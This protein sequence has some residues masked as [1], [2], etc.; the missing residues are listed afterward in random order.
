M[1][2]GRWSRIAERHGGG[3]S[4]CPGLGE[5]A[6]DEVEKR[7]SDWLKLDDSFT[8]IL[9]DCI[10]RRAALAPELQKNIDEAL[11]ELERIQSGI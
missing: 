2:L 6:I 11:T 9:R 7:V 5:V 8:K 10:E 4:C 1:L 3:C